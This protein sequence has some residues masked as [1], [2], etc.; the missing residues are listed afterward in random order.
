[1]K[2]PTVGGEKK[3]RKKKKRPFILQKLFNKSSPRIKRR[4]MQIESEYSLA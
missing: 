3:E 4:K 1:M 2:Q